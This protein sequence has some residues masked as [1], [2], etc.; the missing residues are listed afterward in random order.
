[1]N[2]IKNLHLLDG[3]VPAED[4]KKMEYAAAL[5][6]T[7]ANIIFKIVRCDDKSVV[8]QAAQGRTEADNYMPKKRLIEIVHET[9]GD[10]FKGRKITVNPIEYKQPECTVVTPH[11]I[12][13]V[14]HVKGLKLKRIAEETGVDY[15]QLSSVV[16][17]D[18]PLSK[19][20]KAMFFYYLL[21]KPD[22]K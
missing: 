11:W 9:F 17:G 2:L 4:H 16:T 10:F 14:M 22:K 20:M 1:M 7:H 5:H 3:Y 21:S 19:A 12:Q 18:R 13:E 8:I 6:R 15:T